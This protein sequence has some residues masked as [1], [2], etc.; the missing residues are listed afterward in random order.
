MK[1]GI[2]GLAFVSML[3]VPVVPARAASLEGSQ[4]QGRACTAGYSPC[5]VNHNG[6]DYDCYGGGGNGPHYTKP[7]VVYHVHGS[8][9]YRLDTNHNHL[10]CE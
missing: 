1:K 8:D 10:G 5:L 3:V 2:L 9:P 7:E 4:L 6:S